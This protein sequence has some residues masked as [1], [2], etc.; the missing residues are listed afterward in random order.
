LLTRC[1]GF[2]QRAFRDRKRQRV[3]KL[4]AQLSAL[5]VRTNSL[6][7]D[8]E[9][10]QHELLRAREEN[11]ALRGVAQ[12][13]PPRKKMQPVRRRATIKADDMVHSRPTS[14]FHNPHP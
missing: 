7:S 5:E 13:Q 8:N 11:G 6:A 14:G 1:G 10:L 9:R 12:S 2:R 4:E 3:Q